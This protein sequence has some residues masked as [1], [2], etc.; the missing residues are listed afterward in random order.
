MFD[1]IERL[2]VRVV[3][4][5]H[6]AP[7]TDVAAALVRAR[8]RL[9]GFRRQPER[10]ARHGVKVMIKYHVMEERRIGRDALLQWAVATPFLL[11]AWRLFGSGTPPREWC[12]R[13]V[14][15]LIGQ[16]VLAR[17]GDAVVDR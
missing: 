5:G 2:P 7:F 12:A 1:A 14:D 3:I 13:F 15:E 11:A 4:P 10:H 9:D 17:E 8:S 6:G 16:G